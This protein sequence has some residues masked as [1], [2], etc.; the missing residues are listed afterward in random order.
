MDLQGL[1][2]QAGAAGWGCCAFR[3]LILP[4][5]AWQKAEHLC[6]HPA[7]VFVAAFPYLTSP[8]PRAGN[9]SLYARGEDY[10]R[11]LLRR[12][13]WAAEELAQRYPD[14]R[15]VPGSDASPLDERQCARLAGLGILGRH[16]LLILPPYG[17]WVFLG[18]ILTDLELSSAPVP[19]PDCMGC[20]ACMRACP[21]GALCE[22]GFDPDRCLSALTQ[23]KG[24]LTADEETLLRA[25]PLIWGCDCCQLAG[26]YHRDPLGTP[27]PELA[28][29]D[30]ELPYLDSLSLSDLEGLTNHT[31]RESY[32]C[33]AFAWR[34]PGV[35]RRNLS[36]KNEEFS[37]KLLFS[38][39][40]NLISWGIIL[41]VKALKFSRRKTVWNSRAICFR[42]AATC[43]C[44][45]PLSGTAVW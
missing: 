7:G 12:L 13:T 28:G 10:H 16:G 45:T 33:R 11:V 15:F 27:L 3:D 35:L 40:T 44:W 6:P 8:H 20:G 25:H 34:G 43:A 9:L 18:T 14:H 29:A 22:E 4:P 26:P 37:P 30:T 39:C 38:R 31:F 1:F 42:C 17:S 32:G 19:A 5:E 21:T 41:Q 36:L 24:A 23:R 2:S